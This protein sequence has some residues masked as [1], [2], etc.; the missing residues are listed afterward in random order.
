MCVRAC[1]YILYIHTNSPY[2]YII[3]KNQILI[4]KKPWGKWGES[5]GNW[6][7]WKA[8]FIVF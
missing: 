4:V 6:G 7:I 1:M 2:E 3:Y 8:V 5:G